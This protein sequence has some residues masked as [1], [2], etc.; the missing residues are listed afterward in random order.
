MNGRGRVAD[1]TNSPTAD[2]INLPTAVVV[3][4]WVHAESSRKQP[5]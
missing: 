2:E 4:G 3:R 5:S 1:P